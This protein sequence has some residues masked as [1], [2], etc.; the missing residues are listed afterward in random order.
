MVKQTFV[1][2]LILDFFDSERHLQI[3]IDISGYAISE[4]LSQLTLNDLS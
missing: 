2:A 3:E 4:I 1:E